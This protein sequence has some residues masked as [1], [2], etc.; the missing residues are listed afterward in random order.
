MANIEKVV[1]AICRYSIVPCAVALVAWV[2]VFVAYII[3]RLFGQGWL[4]VEEY[5]GYW[6]VFLAYVPLAYTMV[7]QGHIKTDIV[8]SRLP[9]KARSILEVCTDGIALVIACCLLA[10]SIGWVLRGVEIGSRS[11]TYFRTLLW[12]TYLP[13]SIGLALLILILM[14]KL[15][16]GVMGLMQA[17]R[18]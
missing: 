3:S 16:H 8:T 2:F 6:L 5:T 18:Q 12:P 15:G 7:T 1:R 11:S 17:K 9:G 4:F 14:M 10:R 13:V